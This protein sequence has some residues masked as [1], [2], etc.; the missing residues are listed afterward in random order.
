M[1][2]F[3]DGENK[4]Q[5]PVISE[6]ADPKSAT[7]KTTAL[8]IPVPSGTHKIEARKGD[9]SVVSFNKMTFSSNKMG[10]TATKGGSSVA[11]DNESIMVEL[12]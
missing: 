5:L 2:L 4:G 1:T 6:K 7:Q 3:I 9:G 10:C 11:S 8:Y 12:Y